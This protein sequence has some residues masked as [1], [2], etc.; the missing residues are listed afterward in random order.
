[1]SLRSVFALIVFIGFHSIGLS[2]TCENSFNFTESIEEI[3][4]E[5]FF[6]EIETLCDQAQSL[7]DNNGKFRFR[8]D[9]H[10][11]YGT[12]ARIRFD[13]FSKF[14]D[15]V[16]NLRNINEYYGSKLQ[17]LK[18]SD[19]EIYFQRVAQAILS[20]KLSL[21]KDLPY[22]SQDIVPYT[23]REKHVELIE[24]Y[25]DRLV[26][27]AEFAMVETGYVLSPMI[28]YRIRGDFVAFTNPPKVTYPVYWPKK[29]IVD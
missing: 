3:S 19:K 23:D 6:T 29:R 13:S 2:Q 14:K 1:M 7:F 25:G 15:Q 28:D 24:N 20:I 26:D 27:I 16:R 21:L 4:I 11:Y 10:D 22:I 12:A 17:I 5:E 18:T 8:S 9:E